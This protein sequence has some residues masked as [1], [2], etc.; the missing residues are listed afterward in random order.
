MF[1]RHVEES[2]A[3]LGTDYLDLMQFHN[4][5]TR[6]KWDAVGAAGGAYEAALRLRDQGKVRHVGVT[7]H[8]VRL[9]GE[10]VESGQFETLQVPLNFV[11]DDAA[12]PLVDRCA[13]V[14]VG[15][16]AMK[17]FAG[18]AI[19]DA[20][21]AL[22]YLQQFPAVVP[23][24]GIETPEEL[25]QVIELYENPQPPTADERRRIGQLKV[26]IGKVF[27]RACG[28]C[29]PC[30]QEIAIAMV[31][32]ARSFARRMPA[33]RSRRALGAHMARLDRCTECR[34]CV[35]RCPYDLDI[36]AMLPRMREWFDDWLQSLDA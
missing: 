25:R 7:T 3:R 35:E 13:D 33:D 6:E 16:V 19:E 31:L 5:G 34:Q 17:P 14:G 4:I 10:M 23:I 32:R 36:P 26:E 27:C 2:L 11:A 22:A 9:A 12:A 28:Y 1:A 18:G 8:D 30:P 21:L 20:R 15:F 24:P 29:Q